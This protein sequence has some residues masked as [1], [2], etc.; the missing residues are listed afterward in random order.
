LQPVDTN[1][2]RRTR[3][4]QGRQNSGA[5]ANDDANGSGVCQVHRNISAS[6]SGR[7]KNDTIDTFRNPNFSQFLWTE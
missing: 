1:R 7:R 3:S 5:I 6:T 2:Y 4:T